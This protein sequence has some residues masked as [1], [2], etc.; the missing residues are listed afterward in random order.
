ML[1]GRLNHACFLLAWLTLATSAHASYAQMRLD[2]LGL[3]LAFALAV[4]CAVIVDIALFARLFRYRAAVVAGSIVALAAV[5]LL[6]S[7]VASPGERTGFFKGP[8]GGA[9]LVVLAV[10]SAVVLPF[11][12]V[13]PFAQYLYL[14]NGRRWPGWITAWMALQLS[15]LPGFLVLAGTEEFF[16]QREY[17]AGEA[18]GGAARAGGIGA[19]VERAEERRERIW[20][21][22]WRSPW[23]QD[24]ATGSYVRANA[25]MLGVAKGLDASALVAANEPLGAPDRDALGTLTTRHFGAYGVPNIRARLL[26]DALEPGR[27]A[28]VLAPNGLNETGVVGEEVIPVLLDR[29][30]RHGA[31]RLCPDGRM[32]DADRALLQALVLD[33]GRVWN[34]ETRSHGMRPQWENFPQRIGRLCRG[35]E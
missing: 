22:G 11:L 6:L 14:R 28:R 32:V 23:Q 20:G 10:T 8:P 2:G 33:K 15:L 25:W 30:E 34:V 26:W 1:N 16:W 5:F 21:T 4:A 13:A 3:L 31:P 24:P 19:V 7:Q 12:V 9:A 17:R 35:P 27:F 18:E 29:L